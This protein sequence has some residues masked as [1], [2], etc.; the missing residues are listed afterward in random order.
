LS[1]QRR[2]LEGEGRAYFLRG[3]MYPR[4][5]RTELVP[6]TGPT[7]R[8]RYV[9]WISSSEYLRPFAETT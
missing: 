4:P 6:P 3:V 2:I 5:P 9:A 1:R 7:G 8:P